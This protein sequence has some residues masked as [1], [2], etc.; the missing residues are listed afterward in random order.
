MDARAVYRLLREVG[1]RN[2]L[3]P[4]PLG[5]LWGVVGELVDSGVYIVITCMP[6]GASGFRLHVAPAAARDWLLEVLAQHGATDVSVVVDPID[7][8][9][10]APR[11]PWLTLSL[12]LV[13][14]ALFGWVLL[15]GG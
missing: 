3:W 8:P 1:F 13:S 5:Q 14:I 7:T 10:P 11:T 9:P 15:H 2:V 12:G 4:S 6:V